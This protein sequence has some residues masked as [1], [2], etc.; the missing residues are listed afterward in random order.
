VQNRLSTITAAAAAQAA[1]HELATIAG[2]LKQLEEEW[3][4]ISGEL[5]GN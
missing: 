5:E 1:H 4:A 3:L 2:E